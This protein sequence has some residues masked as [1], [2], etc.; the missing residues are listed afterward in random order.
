MS[1]ERLLKKAD[2]ATCPADV[3]A[4]IALEACRAFRVL[5]ETGK[6]TA[7]A[8]TTIANFPPNCLELLADFKRLRTLLFLDAGDLLSAKTL[9]DDADGLELVLTEGHSITN[10]KDEDVTVETSLISVETA[11]ASNDLPSARN[12]FEKALTRFSADEEKFRKRRVA[13]LERRKLE[14]YFYDLG[15]MIKLFGLT[16]EIWNGFADAKNSLSEFLSLVVK[17]NQI[18]E[19]KKNVN[20]PLQSRLE[21][22]LGFWNPQIAAPSGI[23][24]AEAN[25]WF[26]FG[27]CS[28]VEMIASASLET[29]E[30]SPAENT[31]LTALVEKSDDTPVIH[32]A[33]AVMERA[34]DVLER[35]AH[36]IPAFEKMLKS[37]EERQDFNERFFG[38]HLLDVDLF[39][40]LKQC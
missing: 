2:E 13:F 14:N 7:F 36:T 11:L 12:Y 28:G 35:F 17:Q 26:N 40:L 10:R 32:A 39:A 16:I 38:G 8:D 34:A 5:G 37:D 15:Q 4:E 19:D 30:T 20:I 9:I 22:L 24:Y 27:N 21:C 18:A 23:C 31:P 6:A 3:R 29:I 33:S 25:R 1:L